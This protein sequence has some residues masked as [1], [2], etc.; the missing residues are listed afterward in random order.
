MEDSFANALIAAVKAYDGRR[1]KLVISPARDFR[2]TSISKKAHRYK[3][4]DV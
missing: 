2:R 4:S 1:Q 3:V